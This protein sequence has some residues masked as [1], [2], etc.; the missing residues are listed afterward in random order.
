MDD[1][2][3]VAPCPPGSWADCPVTSCVD[4]FAQRPDAP[5]G[6]YWLDPD[7]D[8][9]PFRTRCDDGGWTLLL[10]TADDGQDTWTWDARDLWTT[11]ESVIGD[12]DALD[13]DFKSPALHELPFRELKFRHLPSEH[14]MTYEAGDGGTSLAGLLSHVGGPV[15]W[16]A[17][18][19]FSPVD[20]SLAL[21]GLCDDNLYLNPVDQDGDAGCDPAEPHRSDAWGPAWSG[22]GNDGCPFDDVGEL[23][24]LGPSSLEDPSLEYGAA[25]SDVS[26]G[27][28]FGQALGLNTGEIGTGQN[29]MEVLAR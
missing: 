29:R 12:V 14:W 5:D 27:I 21:A 16:T 10:V 17:G 24:G 1:D 23:T 15:C 11:D 18:E 19:G 3:S 28:G 9:A 25:P 22:G 6:L 4:L 26:R 13:R 20:G 2:D 8:G 7:A